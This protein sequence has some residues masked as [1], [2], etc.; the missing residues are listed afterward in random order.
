MSGWLKAG[1]IGAIILFVLDVLNI[2]P[3]LGCITLPL[4]LIVYV[5]IGVLAA[6]YMPPKRQSGAGA[7]QGALAALVAS[8]IGGIMNIII[9]AVR[10]SIGSPG[11]ALAKIPPQILRQ[12]HDAGIDPKMLTG[13]GAGLGLSI[14]GGMICCTIGL[15]IAAILGAI[16]GAIY[17]ATK[18]E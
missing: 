7:G 5:A 8:L 9:V 13:M 4:T 18:P 14:G 16:G 11:R 1:L 12:L 2:I 6:S 17:A 3:I 15:F 10:A